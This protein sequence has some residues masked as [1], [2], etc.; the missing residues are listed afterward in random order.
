ME[1]DTK[2]NHPIVQGAWT[3]YDTMA[4]FAK[5]Y[6]GVVLR[7][8]EEG[9]G[10]WLAGLRDGDILLNIGELPTRCQSDYLGARLLLTGQQVVR[11]IRQHKECEAILDMELT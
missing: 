10:F 1:L 9:T 7:V 8:V 6:D 3:T 11:Y 2:I 5:I 4:E